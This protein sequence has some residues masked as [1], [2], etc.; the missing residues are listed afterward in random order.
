MPILLVHS[1]LKWNATSSASM[2]Y[3]PTFCS[4]EDCGETDKVWFIS[5]ANR[6]RFFI[7]SASVFSPSRF[8][9]LA[10]SLNLIVG[11]TKVDP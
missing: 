1:P 9:G 6:S 11:C 3:I 2:L 5:V 4:A 8:S 7:K 10:W